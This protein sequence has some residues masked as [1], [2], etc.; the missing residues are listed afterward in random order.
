MFEHSPNARLADVFTRARAAVTARAASLEP[1][2]APA[3]VP[4]PAKL[5]APPP[6]LSAAL[7]RARAAV[8]GQPAPLPSDLS[9]EAAA[10]QMYPARRAPLPP[11]P[12]CL[13]AERGPADLA[14]LEAPRPASPARP[15]VA[16]RP[17]ATLPALADLVNLEALR[18]GPRRL[19]EL[20]HRLAGDA[21]RVKL[22]GRVAP[23]VMVFHQSKEF[24]ARALG[25]SLVT[26]W[27]WTAELKGLGLL[28][29]R[30]HKA[31]TTHKGEK[32]TRNDGMLYAVALR[33][34]VS[35][36]LRFHDLKHEYRNLDADRRD[37]K[38]AYQTVNASENLT[39]QEWYSRL[40]SWAVN[41]GCVQSTPVNSVDAYTVLDVVY[42]LPGVAAAHPEHRPGIIGQLAAALARALGD[43]HSLRWYAALIWRAW[44]EE[45]E[46][47][48][49]LQALAATLT[50]LDA[51][52][53]EWAGLRNPGAVL[54]ARLA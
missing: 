32:V 8:S 53:A 10:A 21:A 37:G 38:T 48:P 29:A 16:V 3:P 13:E 44:R 6:A 40:V 50:R 4:V 54:A 24:V 27:R 15:R 2:S 52:R 47:R 18:D 39:P 20:L 9:S 28:D 43:G 19:L 45:R 41:P 11:F 46:N 31:T 22:A 1:E 34:H 5:P 51:D 26:V 33:P 30:A 23:S 7:E 35:P 49:G 42:A 25:V 12:A 36:R 17:P 14:R